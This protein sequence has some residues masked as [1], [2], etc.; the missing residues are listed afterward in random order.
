M[1]CGRLSLM[2][3]TGGLRERKKLETRHRLADVAARLFAEHGYDAV[4]V[5]DVARAAE[6][7][8]QT[9]YNYFPTKPDLV[10]DRA[11]EILERSRRV[12]A[13]R[14]PSETPADAI[15]ALVHEDIDR[16]L[17]EDPALARGEFPALCLQSG[18][19]RRYALEFRAD[20]AEALARAIAETE[21]AVPLLVARAHAS[22]L[23]AVIHSVTER[24]G[25]A[26]L[27]DADRAAVAREL[28]A[29]VDAALA[30]AAE[31]FRATRSRA[32]V[33]S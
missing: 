5:T 3:A 19:L 18:S 27:A 16:L 2:S 30:D 12:V 11:D 22:G 4:T 26:V 24:I 33:R 15:C 14:A 20:Q 13:E 29:E 25:A 10:L 1:F 28:R 23:V 17:S 9:V 31:S 8:D 7:A 21:A 32:A 6:V